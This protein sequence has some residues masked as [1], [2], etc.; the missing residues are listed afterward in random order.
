MRPVEK[1]KTLIALHLGPFEAA[2]WSPR[3]KSILSK[4]DELVIQIIIF[5][6]L[7]YL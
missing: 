4:L 1:W 2:T 5:R 7:R 3:R 6:L